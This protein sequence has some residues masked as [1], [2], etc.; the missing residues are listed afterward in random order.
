MEF[1]EAVM[2][3]IRPQQWLAKFDWECKDVP[4]PA[5]RDAA[6][7]LLNFLNK[8]LLAG[9]EFD[10]SHK[11]SQQDMHALHALRELFVEAFEREEVNLGVFIVTPK[12]L[13]DTKLLL[14]NPEME[15]P[16]K[17]RPLLPQQMLEDFKQ[18]ARCL[19]FEI[20][21]ACAF[22]VCRGTEALILEYYKRLSGHS[23]KEK[24]KDWGI[25]V[26]HLIKN[27]APEKITTRL[28]EIAKMDRNAYIHP[29]INVTLDEAPQ[30]FKLCAAVIFYMGQE[31]ERLAP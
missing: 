27:G 7:A 9:P 1:S 24:R 3:M 10:I 30:L 15:F 21:T 22:H 29:D 12:G 14:E 19:A 16:E 6:N 5:T 31:L 25:Y 13:Y 18:A 26:D 20:P 4:L 8:W 23:W 11:F 2:S 17:I 28:R